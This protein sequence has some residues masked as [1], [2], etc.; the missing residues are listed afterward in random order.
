MKYFFDKFLTK[1]SFIRYMAFGIVHNNDKKLLDERSGHSMNS[2]MIRSNGGRNFG[3]TIY[4][5]NINT[6]G[7][8]FFALI[9]FVLD[10]IYC[11]ETLG[12][13]PYVSLVNTRYNN[14]LDGKDN[15]FEYYYQ[16]PANL[17]ME[18]IQESTAVAEFKG[19][20]RAWL[21]A[22]FMNDTELLAGYEFDS[23]LIEIMGDISKRYLFL[24]KDIKEKILNDISLIGVTKKT[25][26]I[27]Y[28][29]NAFK[30]GFY[31]HPICLEIENYYPYINECLEK[32]FD[33]IFIA[34][35]DKI[36]LNKIVEH[37]PNKVIYYRDTERSDDGIDVHDKADRKE[38][39]GFMLGYEVLRDMYTM[40]SCDGL[41]CGKSQV[42]FA[43]LVEKKARDEEF[44]YFK[45]I[46][47]GINTKE[48]KGNV[49]KYIKKLK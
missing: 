15:M 42:S 41:I 7:S 13:V 20:H 10:G 47:L 23:R 36:A 43:T 28:R 5:I 26:A 39:T 49:R 37:Y 16:Q 24:R 46:D 17:T 22:K 33:K 4:N 8:G 31:G 45:L 6:S 48:Q 30:V 25:I 18:D 12:F 40:A 21:E 2:F 32:G 3:K 11:S 19:E 9:R 14:V 35:D 34:T 44:E 29:G 27:H 1:H 38:K